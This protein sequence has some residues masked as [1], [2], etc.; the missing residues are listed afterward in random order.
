VGFTSG[1][2]SGSYQ[3]RSIYYTLDGDAPVFLGAVTGYASYS[4]TANFNTIRVY[5][6]SGWGTQYGQLVIDGQL[7][8]CGI[9]EPEGLIWPGGSCP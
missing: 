2:V 4:F 9:I 5:L 6:S 1:Y 8:D 7:A 3:T